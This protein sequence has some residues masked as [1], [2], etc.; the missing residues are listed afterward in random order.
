MS[1]MAEQLALFG[2]VVG[3][4]LLLSGVGFIILAVGGALRRAGGIAGP[5]RS[6]PAGDPGRV[7]QQIREKGPGPPGPFRLECLGV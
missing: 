6:C 1:Y 2:I 5:R 4:A 3:V 7:A